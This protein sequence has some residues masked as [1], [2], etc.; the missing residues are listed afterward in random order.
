M[1]VFGQDLNAA[2]VVPGNL[3]P[4]IQ[5]AKVLANQKMWNSFRIKFHLDE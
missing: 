3:Y 5:A 4:W 1:N 2:F